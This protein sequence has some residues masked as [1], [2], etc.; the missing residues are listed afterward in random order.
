MGTGVLIK[1]C[2][3]IYKVAEVVRG[4]IY[5]VLRSNQ[6]QFRMKEMEGKNSQYERRNSNMQIFIFHNI[7][8]QK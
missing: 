4:V 3:F 1:S 8:A 2:G 5:I 6:V 7:M